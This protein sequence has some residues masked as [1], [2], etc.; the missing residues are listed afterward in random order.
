MRFR[1]DTEIILG[2]VIVGL[3]IS[4]VAGLIAKW[5]GLTP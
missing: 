4:V 1:N 5:M 3:A 2:I